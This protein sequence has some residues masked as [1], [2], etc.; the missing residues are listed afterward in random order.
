MT[1]DKA[2]EIIDAYCDLLA[3]ALKVVSAHP[4]YV[5]TDNE[6]NARV[7][8]DGETAHLSWI[9]YESDYYGGGTCSTCSTSFPAELLVMSDSDLEKFQESATAEEQERLLKVRAAEARVMQ[10]R[11]EERDRQEF[12]RLRAKYVRT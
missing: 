1:K 6:D 11:M 8:I 12:A 9:E 10:H 7:W 3:R 5:Y 2:T 4:H